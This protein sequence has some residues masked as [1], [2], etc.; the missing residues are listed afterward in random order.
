MFIYFLVWLGNVVNIGNSMNMVSYLRG[1]M[2]M[3]VAAASTTSTMFVAVMQMFSIPAAFVADSYIR[4]F[5]TVLIFAPIEILGYILLAIQA[6]VPS[7]HPPPCQA[8]SNCEP[9]HG[10]NLNLL[11]LGIFMICIGE[12]AI[13][14]CLP[15][16]GGDQF[17]KSDPVE[18]RLE[19][20]F[21]NWY[22][23]AVSFGGLVGL[24]FIVWLENN[25]G[26]DVGFAVC[27]G[28]VLLGLA[29]WASG[30]PF[31]R[32]RLPS[33]SPFTRILEVLV[34]AF[35]KRNLQLYNNPADGLN[36]ITGDNA[37]GVEVLERTKGLQCLDKAAID[38]GKRGSW[39]LCTVHQVE[40]T[41][42]VIR[43]IPIF[44]TSA[45]GYMP[46]SIILTFTV[47]Q[48]NTMNTRLG[49]INV[50]PATL[51]VIPTVFQ[52]VV[53]VVYDRFIVPIPAQKECKIRVNEMTLWGSRLHVNICRE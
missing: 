19:A 48:G 2:N 11:L 12:G 15:A 29:V 35:K 10:S 16:L 46:A 34:A 7:L 21:F 32:N 44:I 9:V 33:G 49:A 22:T 40:E 28:T 18:Q 3:G 50:P 17:D 6:R 52:L 37:K 36:Q 13:R 20:S 51:F 39:S 26:W 24:V 38:D 43:M 47:Q 42:I 1:T 23:F 25:K 30:F 14:A 27:A 45:L 8:P 31:Y 4:R 53:L 41:K 5:Y